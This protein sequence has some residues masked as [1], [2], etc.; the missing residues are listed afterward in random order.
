MW[1]GLS[2]N[3]IAVACVKNRLSW[4]ER[5]KETGWEAMTQ[6]RQDGGLEWV[7]KVELVRRDGIMDIL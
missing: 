4:L 7:V 2:F 6:L 3:R 1:S 5:K